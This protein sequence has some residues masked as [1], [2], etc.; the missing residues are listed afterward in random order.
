MRKIQNIDLRLR[1]YIICGVFFIAMLV[2]GCATYKTPVSQKP[3]WEDTSAILRNI[4]GKP[5]NLSLQQIRDAIISNSSSLSTY[6]ANIA[7]TLTAPD[8][9]GPVRCT[10]LILYLAQT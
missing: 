9:K 6:R 3:I 7:M 4:Q 5:Q 1:T 2:S 10:G 8:L